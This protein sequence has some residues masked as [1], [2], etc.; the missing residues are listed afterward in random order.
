MCLKK[1][2]SY[3]KT[4]DSGISEVLTERISLDSLSDLVGKELFERIK[5]KIEEKKHENPI[6]PGHLSV[7]TQ[8][9]FFGIDVDASGNV[10]IDMLKFAH[11]HSESKFLL[12]DESEGTKRMFDLIGILTEDRED[13][14]FVVDELENSLHPCLTK[15]FLDLFD[16]NFQGKKMQLIFTSHENTI[17][18][19]DTF[20][21]DELW[22]T[23]KDQNGNGTLYSFDSFS[24]RFD[25]RIAKAYLEGRY[26]A[27]PVFSSP[28]YPSE[29]CEES[30]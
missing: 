26:G 14:V 19:L 5:K 2:Q 4:F 3:I 16:E 12:G 28:D 18:N 25:K 20:R 30:Q 22:F 6:I 17:M 21:R 13:I 9:A 10:L 11:R 23:A 27:V 29:M 15:R 7:R 8:E 24:E 1:T